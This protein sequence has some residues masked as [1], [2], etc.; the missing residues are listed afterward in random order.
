MPDR[1]ALEIA[2]LQ[3]LADS[4]T[5]PIGLRAEAILTIHQRTS[6][7]WCSC[8]WSEL[9]ASFSQHQVQM[10]QAAGVLAATTTD[11]ASSAAVDKH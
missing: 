8:G 11:G 5:A 2:A 3:A 1:A 7:R 9:G 6:I 4:P 10:L